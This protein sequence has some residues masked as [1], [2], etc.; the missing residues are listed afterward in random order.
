MHKMGAL[1]LCENGTRVLFFLFVG[2]AH[3]SVLKDF[4]FQ[5]CLPNNNFAVVYLVVVVS[6]GDCYFNY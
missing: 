5:S 3:S 6:T 1:L 4:F 2:F